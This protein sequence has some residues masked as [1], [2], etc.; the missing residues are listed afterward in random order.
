MK[1]IVGFLFV[2]FYITSFATQEYPFPFKNPYTATII[3]SS[4]LFDK[5]INTNIPVKEYSIDINST[6]KSKYENFKYDYGFKFSLVKQKKKAPLIFMIAGT[7]SS[8]NSLRMQYF[9]SIFYKYGYNVISISSIFNPN[10]IINASKEQMPGLIYADSKDTYEAM[11]LAYNKVIDEIEISDIYL[12]GYSLGGT[13]AAIIGNFDTEENYFNFKRILMINPA[14]NIYKSAKKLDDF[15]NYDDNNKKIIQLYQKLKTI[16][17]TST[18][19]EYTELN[20]EN[21]FKL[22][23][24]KEISDEDKKNIIGLAFRLSSIDIHYTV[25][26]LKETNIYSNSKSYY[27][28]RFDDF[29]KINFA[30]FND[31]ISKILYPHFKKNN[32]TFES[33]LAKTR[34]S[35]IEKYLKNNENIAVFTNEDELILDGEDI[36]FLKDTFG[37]RVIVFP[38]GGHCGNMF[39]P[40]NITKMIN[41]LEKGELNEI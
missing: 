21:I 36:K 24:E 5:S 15:F 25:D 40:I 23:G 35:N 10:F 1:K 37:K 3:G 32:E 2:L 18:I 7:G 27:E 26:I 38:Y 22:F 39:F 34:L 8:H 19:P 13:E 9:Q 16:L 11:K 17:K 12:V 4:I 30:T 29:N 6:E 33:L 20:E 31:Y 28:S 41:F 14:V